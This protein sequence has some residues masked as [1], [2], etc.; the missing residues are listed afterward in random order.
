MTC[1]R[2]LVTRSMETQWQ[3]QGRGPGGSAPHLDQ[4]EARRAENCFWRPDPPY[5]RGR[6]TDQPP[7]P[8]LKV[9]IRHGTG[10]IALLIFVMFPPCGNMLTVSTFPCTRHVSVPLCFRT[11]NERSSFRHISIITFPFF[12]LLSLFM[13]WHLILLSGAPA[14]AK[15]ARSAAP[16]VRKFGK[17]S[18]PENFVMTWSTPARPYTHF[19]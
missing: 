12:L 11:G 14:R 2:I 7:P 13:V 3:I 19:M 8:Y 15:R 6:I 4:T 17:P 5:L 16:W 18:I 10:N 1:F 9:W